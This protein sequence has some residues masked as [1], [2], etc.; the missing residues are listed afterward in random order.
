M[1]CTGNPEIF[2]IS[3]LSDISITFDITDATDCDDPNSGNI[4][5]TVL[6]GS[7]VYEFLWSD[8]STSEDLT[9]IPSGDYFVTITDDFGCSQTS[10]VFNIFR[11]Q[12]LVVDLTTQT[13]AICETSLVTQQNNIS[14][15]GGLPPYEISWSAGAVSLG[16]NT[17][18]TAYENGV[19]NV[20][21]TDQYGCEV[22]TEIIV[23]LDDLSINGASF[24]YVSIGTLNCGLGV[25]D[26]IEFTNTSDGDVLGVTWDFGDGSSPISGEIVTHE[27][28]TVGEFEVTI[29]V[30]YN[31]GCTEIYSEEIQV[32]NGYGIMLPTAFSPNNDGINDTIRPVYNCV[33]DINMSVYDTFGSLIYYENNINLQGWDGMLDG[34]KAEN[35]NYLIV[36]SGTTILGEDINL[37]GVFVLLR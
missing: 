24:D 20:I 9:G 25:F 1:T 21:V 29:S 2:T 10:G 6:G 8:G 31:Y 13:S 17:E 27:Y 16:D 19:Y 30:Q 37:R 3:V 26:E 33:N 14:I 5:I 36:V 35:G 4:D 22:D 23:D 28:M 11:Q 18:M 15:S 32:A 34:K 12:D 7:G